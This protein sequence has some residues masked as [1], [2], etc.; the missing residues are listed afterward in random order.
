MVPLLKG[1]SKKKKKKYV[2]SNKA[3]R[4]LPLFLLHLGWFVILVRMALEL[5]EKLQT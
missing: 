4:K 1:K 2:F 3:I 5:M